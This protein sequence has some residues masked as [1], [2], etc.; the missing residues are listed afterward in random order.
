TTGYI[1]H[2]DFL[3]T[4]KPDTN[5]IPKH[6]FHGYLNI[7]N[8]YYNATFSLHVALPISG[9]KEVHPQRELVVGRHLA[10]IENRNAR[11]LAILDWRSE[12][13][14]SELQS[15]SDLVCRLLLE[16]KKSLR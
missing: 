14:T 7:Y 6:L 13:H 12:E 8:N 10:P 9:A 3:G 15:R 1:D 11:R 5:Q 2:A 16:K 4:I